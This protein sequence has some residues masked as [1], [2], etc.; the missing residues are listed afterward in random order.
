MRGTLTSVQ[1]HH[2]EFLD[3]DRRLQAITAKS[4][5]AIGRLQAMQ[6]GNM[7]AAEQTRHLMKLRQLMMM[8]LDAQNTWMAK[9]TNQEAQID[10]FTRQ[11]LLNA[12][13]P[14]PTELR[15]KLQRALRA[16]PAR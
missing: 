10:A 14:L 13:K 4:E 11:W 5:T 9:E 8:Q 15:D 16:Q 7:I 12:K 3:E 6:A 1:M 2:E